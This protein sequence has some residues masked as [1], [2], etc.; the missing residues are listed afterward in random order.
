MHVLQ[1]IGVTN[2]IYIL[3]YTFKIILYPEY[4]IWRLTLVIAIS[5]ASESH[6]FWTFKGEIE[7]VSERET[8]VWLNWYFP[9]LLLKNEKRLLWNISHVS[10]LVSSVSEEICCPWICCQQGCGGLVIRTEMTCHLRSRGVCVWCPSPV[11]PGEACG[12]F[13]LLAACTLEWRTLQTVPSPDPGCLV[14]LGALCLLGLPNFISD[15]LIFQLPK[16]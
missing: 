5:E 13:C 10:G 1:T 2:C 3:T 6:L 12:A 8:A 15:F 9:R 16:N 11:A 4:E 14:K 7:E